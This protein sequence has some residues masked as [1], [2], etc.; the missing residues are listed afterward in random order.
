M[1]LDRE[2]EM[3]APVKVCPN[4]NAR[5]RGHPNKKFC[6]RACKDAYHNEHNPRG[7]QATRALFREHADTIHPF[8]SEAFEE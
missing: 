1:P 3:S 6:R 4:C 5:F 2:R 7:Y 8:S